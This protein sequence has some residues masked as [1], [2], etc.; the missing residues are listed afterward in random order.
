M[1]RL[2]NSKRLPV[3]LL[4]A[5]LLPKA[6]NLDRRRHVPQPVRHAGVA[7]CLQLLRRNRQIR[8]CDFEKIS[9]LSRRGLLKAFITHLGCAP[10]TILRTARGHHACE[11]LT[12]SNL[13]VA[14][15]AV[16][17]G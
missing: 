8:L 5:V 10:G 3:D 13:L 9:G 6:S 7:R 15:V 2:I 1:N 12:S 17:C 4:M 11:L 16:R 14:E